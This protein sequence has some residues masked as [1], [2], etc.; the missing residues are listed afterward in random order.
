[1]LN[2]PQTRAR[3]RVD[4]VLCRR[5]HLGAV[6]GGG[7]TAVVYG[8]SACGRRKQ[9]A[10]VRVLH[11]E[12]SADEH[13]RTRFFRE[14]HTGNQV[15]HPA[16]V[17]TLSHGQ[18]EDG[19]AFLV[20]DLVRGE[21]LERR[22]SRGTLSLT[23]ALS[24][25]DQLLDLLV[26]A[27]AHGI[28]HRSLSPHHL[29]L[30]PTGRLR[31][32]DFGGARLREVTAGSGREGSFPGPLGYAP[33]EQV[34]GCAAPDDP[35]CDLHA[36]GAI[37]HHMLS[38][39]RMHEAVTSAEQ[40]ARTISA[41][42][43]S[44]G[45][46]APHLPSCVVNVVDTA[47]RYRPEERWADASDMQRALRLAIALLSGGE[48]SSSAGAR[49]WRRASSQRRAPNDISPAG[50]EA[51]AAE[52]P[53]EPAPSAAE[54]APEGGRNAPWLATL[55]TPDRARSRRDLLELAFGVESTGEDQA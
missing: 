31:V 9:M 38:G 50:P 51:S 55:L 28:V 19:S 52:V 45:A 4:S 18:A 11:S 7:D 53:P 34:R 16:V 32:L 22:L 43:P 2:E 12:L 14:G 47:L 21:T 8:A 42:P 26:C 46:T 35:R 33:P 5:W 40:M 30:E 20:M 17:R 15:P 1:M 44:L 37:L 23:G 36:A 48:G 13:I 49:P 39:R 29:M 6:L 54:T 10:A 3:R 24:V 25:A 41:P 27:H